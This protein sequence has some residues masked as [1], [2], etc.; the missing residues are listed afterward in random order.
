VDQRAKAG[1]RSGRSWVL[2]LTT[3]SLPVFSGC[4]TERRIDA[5]GGR[6]TVLEARES[7]GASI[8]RIVGV[9]SLRSLRSSRG[10]ISF[11][12]TYKW[13]EPTL[14]RRA[15]IK[16]SEV[17]SLTV[18]HDQVRSDGKLMML[19]ELPAAFPNEAEAVRFAEALLAL[20]AAATGPDPEETEVAAFAVRAE[21]WR[22]LKS[23][24]AM[25]DSALAA[26]AMAED[27]FKKKDFASALD[28]YLEALDQH[29]QWPEG[30]YNAALLAAEVEDF[31]LAA[32]HM[33]RYL[34]LA[35]DAKDVPACKEKLLMWERKAKS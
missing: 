33:R 14:L 23:K 7:L 16:F 12:Y 32:H 3:M 21:A 4:A 8:R 9:S 28:A 25:P 18:S 10:R 29:P 34:A 19:G 2:F 35:P 5:P 1:P 17:G 6:M 30:Q 26:K 24:P 11:G 20:K 31:E 15:V 13:V 22:A 27:A